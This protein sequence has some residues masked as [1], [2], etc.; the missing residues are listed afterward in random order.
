MPRYDYRCSDHG[1]EFEI[2]QSFSDEAIATCPTCGSDS[3]RVIHS[4]P[5]MFKGSGFYVNDYAKGGGNNGSSKADSEKSSESK[6]DTTSDSDSKDS[7]KT[8]SK[9]E[10]KKEPDST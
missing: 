9:A 7:A 4:V 10:S 1:H 5:V 8:E 3:R 6:A 2:K